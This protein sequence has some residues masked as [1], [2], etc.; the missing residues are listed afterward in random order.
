M[1]IEFPAWTKGCDTDP[2]NIK[3]DYPPYHLNKIVSTT[4][5]NSGSPAY[6]LIKNF[7]W[8][9]EDQNLVAAY[10]TDQGMTDEA[11]AAKWLGDNP[12]AW[13]AWLP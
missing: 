1:H 3:C 13:K 2:N 11:A 5:A 8:K 9:N 6:T 12:D 10:I 4:F 7:T